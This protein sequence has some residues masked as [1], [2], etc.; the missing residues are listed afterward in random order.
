M[1]AE[2]ERYRVR[3]TGVRSVDAQS[4]TEA[5]RIA[6]REAGLMDLRVEVLGKSVDQALDADGTGHGQ[7]AG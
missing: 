6:R 1:Q 7:R 2:K 4:A 5:D 3:L